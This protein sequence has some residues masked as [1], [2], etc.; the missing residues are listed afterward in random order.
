MHT[1]IRL[2]AALLLDQ[3]T[4]DPESKGLQQGVG[5]QAH[6]HCIPEERTPPQRKTFWATRTHEPPHSTPGRSQLGP[7]LDRGV[8]RGAKP[9]DSYRCERRA[10][11]AYRR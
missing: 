7:V 6:N 11:M 8:R 1:A 9:A 2:K 10:S 5:F 3:H 4:A